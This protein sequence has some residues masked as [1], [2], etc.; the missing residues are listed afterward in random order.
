[1]GESRASIDPARGPRVR[2]GRI[3]R[4]ALVANAKFEALIFLLLLVTFAAVEWEDE[5]LLRT[6]HFTPAAMGGY[7]TLGQTD[8]AIGGTST[9]TPGARPLSWSCDITP[10]F[11]YPYCGYELLFDGR[12]AIKGVDLSNLHSIAF[13]IAYSGPAKTLRFHL[14]NYDP[15]YSKP[16]DGKSQKF[17]KVEFP[18]ESGKVQTVDFALSDFSVADWWL[19]DSAVPPKLSHPQF[20]NIVA[21]DFQTGTVPALGHHRFEVR[22]ITLRKAAL[23]SAQWYLML[24]GIWVVLIGAFLVHRIRNLKNELVKR[25]ALEVLARHQAEEAEEAARRDHLTQVFNRRGAA[26]RFEKLPLAGPVAL[27]LIDI[28][29]FKALNDRFGHSNGDDVLAAIAALIRRSAR[30]GDTVAR[31]GGEEFL[32]LCPGLD[33][34]AALYLAERVRRRIE[35]ARFGECGKVTASL[36]V[37]CATSTEA[38]LAEL[39]ALADLALYA[40]KRQGRNRVLPYRAEMADAA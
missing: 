23:T 33:E 32:I 5:I 1:M 10:G 16:G 39:V 31:W 28:D 19:R 12:R 40:A 37:H 27:I 14:K 18:A 2:S 34:A 7:T 13:T 36:G 25:Q 20:D 4:S 26:E 9:I 22:E 15:A 29:R 35:H 11:E 17:N 21:L 30:A 6:T 3:R 38:D 24:L 8:A